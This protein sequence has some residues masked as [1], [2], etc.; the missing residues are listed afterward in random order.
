MVRTSDCGSGDPGSIPGGHPQKIILSFL[1]F[2]LILKNNS[3]AAAL[4]IVLIISVVSFLIA[5]N[6]SI[7]GLGELD[8]SY[9]SSKEK[10]VFYLADSC[11]E[12]VLHRI[13]YDNFYTANGEILNL[14]NGS[15]I[16][17]ITANN[18]NRLVNIKAHKNNYY[19]NINVQAEILTN[20]IVLKN[21]REK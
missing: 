19:K 20:K 5:K 14:N 3:G 21:F 13:Q 4:F 17:D 1:Y 10:G 7:L 9:T 16:I 11:L 15:C 12:D 8:M 2:M 18:S 6:I